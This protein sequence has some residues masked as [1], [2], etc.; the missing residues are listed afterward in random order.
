M[1]AMIK[2]QPVMIPY[3]TYSVFSLPLLSVYM[4]FSI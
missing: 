3:I 4:V 1:E 2:I